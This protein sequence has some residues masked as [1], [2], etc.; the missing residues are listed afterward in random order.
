MNLKQTIKKAR[1]YLG[2]IWLS[3]IIKRLEKVDYTSASDRGARLGRIAYILFRKQRRRTLKN[4]R[5]IFKEKKTPDQCKGIVLRLFENFFR[6]GFECIA[7]SNLPADEKKNYVRIVGKEKLDNAL[8]S[9]RGVVAL[10]AHFGNF[11]IMMARLSLEEYCVDLLV[12]KMKDERVEALL[13]KL[14]DKLEYHTIYVNGKIQAAK[15]SMS[16]LKKNHVL[17][18]LGDQRQKRAGVDVTFLGLPAKAATGPVSFALSCGAP[19]VP[20]FMVRNSDNVTHTLFIEDP[21]EMSISGEKERD[22]KT[23][24][25]KYTNAIEAYVQK[26][27][28]QWIWNHKRWTS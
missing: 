8:A 20:M 15:S 28:D 22:L 27:P 3:S 24:V 9:G 6:S 2:S 13:Q 4:L 5:S 14:R 26:Y 25:Q 19:I 11:L 17:V 10:S 1:D 7:Y 16:S 23:N 21:I 18:M 12:K